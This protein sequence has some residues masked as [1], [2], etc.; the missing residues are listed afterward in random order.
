MESSGLTGS[1]KNLARGE[2]AEAGRRAATSA[3]P[4][5]AMGVNHAA[6]SQA[7]RRSSSSPPPAAL[8][9][10][11]WP[12]CNANLCNNFPLQVQQLKQASLHTSSAAQAGQEEEAKTETQTT[13]ESSFAC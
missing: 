10:P 11:S 7:G 2:G 12:P 9:F 1:V 4:G 3:G 6:G 5:P 13:L 8:A